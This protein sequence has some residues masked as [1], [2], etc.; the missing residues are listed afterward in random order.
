[1][2]LDLADQQLGR[3]ERG[4]VVLAPQQADLPAPPRDLGQVAEQG[5][6]GAD[7]PAVEAGSAYALDLDVERLLGHAGLVAQHVHQQV[8]AAD[9]AEEAV[10]AARF[11]VAL[12]RPLPEL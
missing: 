11:L 10:V 9:L 4:V 12:D 6:A 5:A 3:P 8:V 2:E 7:L 1:R